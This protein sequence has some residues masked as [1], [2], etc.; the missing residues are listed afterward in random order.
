MVPSGSRAKS[1]SV[2]F[3][4]P[5]SSAHVLTAATFR[6]SRHKWHN[7]MCF[8]GAFVNLKSLQILQR[9]YYR[10]FFLA[11][12]QP[13]TTQLGQSVL[14]CFELLRETLVQT[15]LVLLKL[16]SNTYKCCKWCK[17]LSYVGGSMKIEVRSIN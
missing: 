1:V 12:T 13:D 15:N 4:S 8:Q 10:I 14:P 6:Q 17:P 16:H 7:F 2:C 9:V 11:L 3:H 5:P